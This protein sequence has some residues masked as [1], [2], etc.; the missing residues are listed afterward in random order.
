[1]LSQLIA[2]SIKHSKFVLIAAGFLILLAG[3][4]CR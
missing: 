4:F 3:C 2:F 1:M